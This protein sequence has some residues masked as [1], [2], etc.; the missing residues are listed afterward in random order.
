MAPHNVCIFESLRDENCPRPGNRTE[1]KEAGVLRTQLVLLGWSWGQSNPDGPQ[2]EA[3]WC[4]WKSKPRPKA[5]LGTLWRQL[6]AQFG[7]METQHDHG[8][9]CFKKVKNT[10]F[11]LGAKLRQVGARVGPSWA[12]VEALPKANWADV[13]AMWHRN[14]PFGPCCADMENVWKCAKYEYHSP[15]HF[16]AA[17]KCPPSWSCTMLTDRSI[18]CIRC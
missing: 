2:I 9:R 5:Q 14:G 15:M 4:T 6:R 8:E 13:V 11:K 7:P 3:M 18:R 17:W 10:R 16:L 12:E 1:R